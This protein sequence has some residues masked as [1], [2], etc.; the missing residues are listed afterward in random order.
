MA[1]DN[2]FD[3]NQLRR[4]SELEIDGGGDVVRFSAPED[5]ILKKMEYFRIGESEK[6]VRDIRGILKAQG[7]RVDRGYIR[8]WAGRMALTEI[9]EAIEARLAAG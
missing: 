5:I 6:H 4:A 1:G 2:E 9:W 3:R 8:Q 7:D